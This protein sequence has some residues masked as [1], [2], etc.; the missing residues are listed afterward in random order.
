MVKCLTIQWKKRLSS[1]AMRRARGG[2]RTRIQRRDDREI[3]FDLMIEILRRLPAKSLMKFKCVSKLWSGL[4]CSRYFSN[5]YLLTRNVSSSPSP[6]RPLGLFMS[7]TSEL[8]F[9]CDSMDL[10]NNPGKSDLLSLRLSSS[11]NS[12]EPSLEADLNLPGMG[13]HRME[14]LR[15]LILYI[16]CRKA[17]IYNPTTR[18]SLTLPAVKSNI[19]AQQERHK[20]VYYFFGYDPVHDQYKIVCSV[21]LGSSHFLRITTEYWVFVLEPGG[22]WKKIEHDGQSHVPQRQGLCIN[23]VIYYLAFGHTCGDTIYTFDV[24]SEKFHRIQAPHEVSSF[25][26]SVVFIE[27]GG[28]PSL[29]DYS[30]IKKTGVSELWVLENSGTWSRKTL[31]LKPCQI[32]L[33]KDINIIT[34]MVHGTCQNN[35][36]ILVL[37]NTCYLLYYDLIN[38]DLRKVNINRERPPD[39][40]PYMYITVKDNCENIM[41][42]ET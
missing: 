13:G 24:S 20:R 5:L 2:R 4:I 37:P 34:L 19:F 12:V 26:G 23:G 35:E 40:R 17:C 9:Y 39:R 27:H 41:H 15:G 29:F 6:P 7:F 21:V 1:K 30:H 10:C 25:R 11:S 31:V 3:F 33:V 16:V 32:H 8:H 38:N 14:I 22:F 36:V 28:N 42:L 18:Q